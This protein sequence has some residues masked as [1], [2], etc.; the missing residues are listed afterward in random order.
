MIIRKYKNLEQYAD[1]GWSLL[2]LLNKS[3]TTALYA[4]CKHSVNKGDK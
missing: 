3:N 4:W 1:W 2:F